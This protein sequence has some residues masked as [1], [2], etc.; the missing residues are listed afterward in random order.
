MN[1]ISLLIAAVAIVVG[2]I[3]GYVGRKIV[4]EQRLT[5]AKENAAGDY[6]N[7][8][9]GGGDGEKGGHFRGPRRKP[10]LPGSRG[11]RTQG[12]S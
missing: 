2:L 7:C 5:Q 10:S 4:F 12:S 8:P 11:T 3:A 1:A 6:C 9:K